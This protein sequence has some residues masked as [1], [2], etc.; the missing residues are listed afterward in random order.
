MVIVA[1]RDEPMYG[2]KRIKR[3]PTTALLLKMNFS[4]ISGANSPRGE[5]DR[6]LRINSPLQ[7]VVLL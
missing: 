3:A 1:A 2:I 7:G 6:L 4:E 5:R